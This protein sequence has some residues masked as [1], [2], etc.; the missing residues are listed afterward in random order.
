MRWKWMWVGEEFIQWNKP[1]EFTEYSNT[2]N[3]SAPMKILFKN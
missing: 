1:T 2:L 3:Y